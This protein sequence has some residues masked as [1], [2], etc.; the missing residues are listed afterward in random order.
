[1]TGSYGRSSSSSSNNNGGDGLERDENGVVLL[2]DFNEPKC[3]AKKRARTDFEDD[4]DAEDNGGD[5]NDRDRR[6]FPGDT[7]Q[8]RTSNSNGS[9]Q[10]QQQQQQQH[11]F[12]V[13]PL[14]AK[15][16][17]RTMDEVHRSI[18][19]KE[20]VI[21]MFLNSKY[22]QRLS[23]IKQLGSCF[24]VYRGA[25]HTRF[26]HSLGVAHLAK[27]LCEAIAE[28]QPNLHT[29]KKDILCV[30]LAALCHDL[31]HGPFSHI[32]EVFRCL[33]SKEIGRASLKSTASE[34]DDGSYFGTKYLRDLKKTYDEYKDDYD[35]CPE[36]IWP[37]EKSSLSM[38]DAILKENGLAIDYNVKNL[39]KPLKQIGDGIDASTIVESSSGNVLTNRDLIFVKECIFGD[40]HGHTLP[41][42]QDENEI[43]MVDDL[44]S[45][46]EC[47][48]GCKH[49][50][51]L[52][53]VLDET[54]ILLHVGRKNYEKEWLYDVVSNRHNGIDVDK[55]DYFVRDA[56][57]TI[58]QDGIMDPII[59]DAIVAKSDSEIDTREHFM[60]C[61]ALKRLK[62]V[63]GFFNNRFDLHEQVYQHKTTSGAARMIADIFLLAEPYFRIGGKPLSLCVLDAETF[64]KC[65]DEVFTRIEA[66]AETN[67]N[68]KPA[69]DL[70]E[71]FKA[72]VCYG[73][74][75]EKILDVR[76]KHHQEL[77]DRASEDLHGIAQDIYEI[78]GSH[79]GRQGQEL[80]LNLDDIVVDTCYIH[81][82]Q[83]DKNPLEAVRF[84]N[85][86]DIRS[87][88]FNKDDPL[89]AHRVDLKNH[90]NLE[91]QAYSK[92]CLR[93][94]ARGPSNGM[95]DLVRH[96]FLTW[97]SRYEAG[98]LD[99]NTAPP[100]DHQ[101]AH[102][103]HGAGHDEHDDDE[104]DGQEPVML[105]QD[106]EETDYDH[107]PPPF[108]RRRNIFDNPFDDDH[109]TPGLADAS[110]PPR[111]SKLNSGGSSSP[112]Y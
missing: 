28:R 56:K 64:Y 17:F 38:I 29:T 112:G 26:E 48:L 94:Y 81:E 61:Y 40:K 88:N 80:F 37:H 90:P 8:P 84:V 96:K 53:K 31:G 85:R 76:K 103:A 82:G 87:F 74:A 52:P 111:R 79:A 91:K 110:S 9:R 6:N 27:K 55:M 102:G 46:T 59:D 68:L 98:E 11:S 86:A 57:R 73:F 10:Q 101:R 1:M 16:L 50:Q 100:I 67:D 92:R 69:L 21:Q 95:T 97:D 35:K 23:R 20:P 25:T 75:G 34:Q 44:S 77:W 32:F 60:I 3:P 7:H 107:T 18:D 106:P 5:Y 14:K 19:L 12:N 30:T 72:R 71:R 54:G 2:P 51:A 24:L 58:A 108:S 78:E 43:L 62:A 109:D 93:I 4:D 89:I 15:N 33:L 39:D 66:A 63:Q 65:D 36:Q 105:T 45:V 83:K 42:V 22:Y 99:V 41:E 70:I 104:S 49:N 47:I 13:V